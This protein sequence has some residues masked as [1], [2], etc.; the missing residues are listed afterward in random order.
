M[1]RRNFHLMIDDKFIN[2]FMHDADRISGNNVYI[3]T[4]A[5]PGKFVTS[6]AGIYAPY[7]SKELEKVLSTIQPG[8][9]VFVHWCSPKL[10]DYLPMIPEGAGIHLCF[11]GGDF[12][13]SQVPHPANGRINPFLYDPLTLRFVSGRQIRA[14]HEMLRERRAHA[15]KSGNPKNMLHTWW[16]HIRLKKRYLSGR[17]YTEEIAKRTQFLSRLE[18]V[19]HW[20]KFDLLILE[21]LYGVRLKQRYFVY[22]LGVE[23]LSITQP[24]P[25]KKTLT[26][27]LGNSDTPTNNH[28]D[29]LQA[30][31]RFRDEDIE[32]ICPLNYGDQE[33]GDLVEHKGKSIFGDRFIAL[34]EYIPRETYYDLMDRTDIAVMFHNRGQAGA[35][36]FAFVKKGKKLFMKDQSSIAQLFR[37]HGLDLFSTDSLASLSI[38]DLR[39]PLTSV[40]IQHNIQ[41]LGK[42]MGNEEKR[43]DALKALL[44]PDSPR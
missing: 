23:N 14:V 39:T 44:L 40:Q 37:S 33:Y 3:F 26:V 38:D 5:Y 4:F 10:H 12:L 24:D 7:G 25:G 19:C 15:R 1:Q 35:N 30:L 34:R 9:K 18:A 20:N 41:C 27:W 31:S 32:I 17:V 22:G 28:L 2:D 13:E 43:I 36:V 42:V 6:D 11:W 29:A 21:E 8:D 16:S